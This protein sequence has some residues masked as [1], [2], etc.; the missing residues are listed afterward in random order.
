VLAAQYRGRAMTDALR[1]TILAAASAAADAVGGRLEVVPHPTEAPS[2]WEPLLAALPARTAP[3]RIVNDAGLH[4]RLPGAAFLVTGWSN[5]VYEAVLAGVPAMTV[6]PGRGEPPMPFAAEGIAT[7]VHD[8][9]D[10]AA[11]AP[12]LVVEPGRSSGLARARTA[13][14]DHLGPLD[15]HAAARSADLVARFLAG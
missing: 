14:A 10:A 7:E 13:L 1:A 3:I 4:D 6:H 8:S 11:S 15:G 9:A 12:R 2:S 5:S